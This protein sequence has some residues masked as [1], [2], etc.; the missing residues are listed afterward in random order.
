MSSFAQVLQFTR[1][2]ALRIRHLTSVFERNVTRPFE[3]KATTPQRELLVA[4]VDGDDR[5]RAS[6]G[7]CQDT[8]KIS[9]RDTGCS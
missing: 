8:G 3:L 7:T 4:E 5:A 1:H 9:A 6:V 2:P